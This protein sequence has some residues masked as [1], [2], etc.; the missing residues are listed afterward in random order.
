[1]LPLTLLKAATGSPILVELKDGD[2]YNGRLQSCDAWMN[3][4]LGGGADVICTSSSGESFTKLPQG[5]YIRGSSIK[6]LRLPPTVLEQAAQLEVT[7]QQEYQA[8]RSSGR[9]SRGGGRQFGG[10]SSSNNRDGGGGRGG[11]EGGRGGRD[12]GG[13]GRG[14]G[15]RGRSSDGGGRGGRGGSSS[16]GG[17]RGG[18]TSESG[19]TLAPS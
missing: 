3:M 18:R 12:G 10:R 8:G 14:S 4:N 1:M 5:I 19:R 6:Y 2:T 11:R 13:R 17:G 9:G 15:G 7:Q 16:R